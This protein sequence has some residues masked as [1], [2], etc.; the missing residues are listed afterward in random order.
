MSPR[1][2]LTGGVRHDATQRLDGDADFPHR[3]A[4]R[5]ILAA[6]GGGLT[7]V[8]LL[9]MPARPTNSGC[10]DCDGN[11]TVTVDELVTAVGVA[12]D[13]CPGQTECCGDCDRNGRIAI[14]E[15]VTAVRKALDDSL[16]PTR[17]PTPTADEL[18]AVLMEN[19]AAWNRVDAVRYRM[20]ER[21]H[22]YCL[23][24]YPHLV[25]IEVVENQ[26]V[27]IR[28][29]WTGE[30]VANPPENAYRTVD[31]IFSLIEEAINS[32]ADR[33]SVKYSQHVG[34]PID[35]YIDYHSN[36]FDE[37]MGFSISDMTIWHE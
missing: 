19:R 17:T 31:G 22:C 25:A 1:G 30:E 18:L 16:I 29:V 8:V 28:D 6:T 13:G 37:E 14:S 24:E 15:L 36:V 26:I 2:Q 12:F 7:L 23:F 5:H 34:A 21:V 3:K 10:G 11:G 33:V 32:R 4:V 9:A 35:T 27:S 20:L